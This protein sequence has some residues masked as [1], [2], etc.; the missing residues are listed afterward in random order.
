MP[1]RKSRRR[2]AR[3]AENTEPDNTILYVVGGIAGVAGVLAATG[4]AFTLYELYK[5]KNEAIEEKKIVKTLELKT[6]QERI[7]K[8]C[9][10]I[11]T[12]QLKK[13]TN[14]TKALRDLCDELNMEAEDVECRLALARFLRWRIGY[15]EGTDLAS[16]FRIVTQ[17]LN[18]PLEDLDDGMIGNWLR[19]KFDMAFASKNLVELSRVKKI[20]KTLTPPAQISDISHTMY[21]QV[22]FKIACIFGDWENI[23]LYGDKVAELN[24]V[25]NNPMTGR[26]ESI[27]LLH[28]YSTEASKDPQRNPNWYMMFFRRKMFK[29]RFQSLY[30]SQLQFLHWDLISGRTRYANGQT[31][32]QALQDSLDKKKNEGWKALNLQNQDLWISG[33]LCQMKMKTVEDG[34]CV[35]TGPWNDAEMCLVGLMFYMVKGKPLRIETTLQ[36]ERGEFIPQGASG[37]NKGAWQW[38]GQLIFERYIQGMGAAGA[39]EGGYQLLSQEVH[40]IELVLDDH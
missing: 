34:V 6:L 10:E 39:G 26:R 16:E 36:V 38:N 24:S 29:T 9:T 30:Q 8:A 25:R 21:Y 14:E 35:L 11:L 31:N 20:L 27:P 13:D 4:A 5:S 28:T 12:K 33:A 3:A 18:F 17:L 1:T 37:R 15:I 19:S 40:D 22:S 23:Q 7:E 2:K 32:V